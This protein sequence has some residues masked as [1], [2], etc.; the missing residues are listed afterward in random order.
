[1]NLN[2][3]TLLI[4]KLLFYFYIQS[5]LL[6]LQ[7]IIIDVF[8]R[9]RYN[10]QCINSLFARVSIRMVSTIFKISFFIY[11]ILNT[12]DATSKEYGLGRLVND[13]KVCANCKMVKIVSFNTPYLC[14][15]AKRDIYH[16]KKKFYIFMASKSNCGTQR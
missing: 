15:F 7:E 10:L 9:R 13:S 3:I 8:K 12:Q 16:Q 2:K 1:M 11:L 14:L 4:G 6:F 5:K